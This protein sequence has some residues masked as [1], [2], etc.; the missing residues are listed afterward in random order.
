MGYCPSMTSCLVLLFL[1]VNNWSRWSPAV[2]NLTVTSPLTPLS[3]SEASVTSGT[4]A[5]VAEQRKHIT[6]DQKCHTLGWT[7]IPLF[8]AMVTGVLKLDKPHI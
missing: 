2:F 4:A 5:P 3:L 7:C 6:N 1:V 8:S